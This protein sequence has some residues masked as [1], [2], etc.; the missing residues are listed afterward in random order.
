MS[1]K[2]KL[3]YDIRERLE[4]TTS[5]DEWTDEYLGHLV[6]L[7]RAMLLRER[8]NQNKPFDYYRCGQLIE[9][10]VALQERIPFEVGSTRITSLE[11]IPDIIGVDYLNRYIKVTSRDYDNINFNYICSDRFRY[12]GENRYMQDQVYA[13][14]DVDN[15]LK[16]KSGAN[17]EK[18]IRKM[19]M[20]AIFSEP[21]EAYKL[22]WNKKSSLDFEDT[23][24]PLDD[25]L[26]MLAI[27][28]I[29]KED[30]LPTITIAKKTK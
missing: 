12:V 29:I 28:L 11:Q 3:I 19:H 7:K 18:N 2:R 25:R 14:V 15:K 30:L 23:E 13:T 9:V 24:Y 1:T 16:L 21:E 26:E 17:I 5:S 8:M 6:D 27:E 20:F 10:N 22:L 4:L